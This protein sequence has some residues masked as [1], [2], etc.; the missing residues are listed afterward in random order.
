[1]LRDEDE[2]RAQRVMQAM[3]GMAKLDISRLEAAFNDE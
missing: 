1:M 2:A 3:L